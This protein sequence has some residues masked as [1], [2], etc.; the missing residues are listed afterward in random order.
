LS[1]FSQRI[2]NHFFSGYHTLNRFYNLV[3]EVIINMILG[4]FTRGAALAAFATCA[5]VANAQSASMYF[6]KQGDAAGLTPSFIDV[7]Q[8]TTSVTLSFYVNT[9]GFA[10]NIA[11]VSAM[12]GFDTT[13]SSTDTAV[14]SGNGVTVAHGGT[15]A[16]PTGLPLTWDSTNFAGGGVL[17]KL[18]GGFD[19]SAATRP[20]GLWTTD[21]LVVGDFGFS[22]ATSKH[23]FDLTL[24]LDPSF[25]VGTLRPVTIYKSPANTGAWD[26]NVSDATG[27]IA[28]N[29]AYSGTIRVVSTVPEPATFAV[30]GLGAVA[31][32]RR[33]KK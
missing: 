21:L 3:F 28:F 33:R 20:W 6:N 9:S 27:F 23:M 18:G 26:S 14:P 1:G 32:L 5:L 19:A 12:V 15:N 31:L 17:N 16:A 22:N 2:A 29:P 30:L 13:T 24:T 11:A 4:K 10:Q 25:T 8:G 7:A